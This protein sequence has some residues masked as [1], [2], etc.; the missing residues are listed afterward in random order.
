MSHKLS[1]QQI[2][3]QQWALVNR[4]MAEESVNRSD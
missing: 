4:F 1:E 3:P 2:C